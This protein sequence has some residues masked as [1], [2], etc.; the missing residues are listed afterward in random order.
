MF[1]LFYIFYSCRQPLLL[2]RV[3]VVAYYQKEKIQNNGKENDS[4]KNKLNYKK[5]K[6]IWKLDHKL[7]WFVS[8][9]DL[10]ESSSNIDFSSGK[11]YKI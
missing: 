7:D 6:K 4:F 1:I 8:H 5:P 2:V 3:N 9:H 10:A 11:L